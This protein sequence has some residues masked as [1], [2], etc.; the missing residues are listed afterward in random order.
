MKYQNCFVSVSK[1]HC[2]QL[3]TK[4]CSVLIYSITLHTFVVSGHT[5]CL[6]NTN[7]DQ[8]LDHRSLSFSEMYQDWFFSH[9]IYHDSGHIFKKI[10]L[11]PGRII[12]VGMPKVLVA[13]DP[14][15]L[16]L[17]SSLLLTI[18][19]MSCRRFFC[20][21]IYTILLFHFGIISETFLML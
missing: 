2:R 14:M 13:I 6:W 4:R 12:S 15:Y 9:I 3:L 7:K 1:K 18:L 19:T 8:S 17:K 11:K 10:L 20:L 21:T 5:V 16:R